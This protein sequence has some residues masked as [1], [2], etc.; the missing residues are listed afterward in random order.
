[1]TGEKSGRTKGTLRGRL[2]KTTL[3]AAVSVGTTVWLS[4]GL[5]AVTD[6][7]RARRIGVLPP[8][9]LLAVLVVAAIAVA[10]A[11]RLPSRTSLP[12][13]LSLLI[14][15][16]WIPLH[17]PDLFLAWTG[18]AVLFVWGAIALG[19]IAMFVSTRSVRPFAVVGDPR[20]APRV[21]AVLAFVTFLAVW[22]GQALPPNG[23]EPHYLVIAQSLLLDR[24]VKVS[25]NYER[26][27]YL[28][29][30]GGFLRPHVTRPGIDG[31]LYSLHA[32]GLPA[33]VA[34]AFA[35]GGYW[36]VVVW[37]AAFAAIGTALVWKA[38]YLLTRDPGAA[39][40][41]WA[42]VA[43]TVPVVLHGTLVYPDP[44]AGVVL[45]GGA[46]ALVV[47]SEHRRDEPT[48]RED[49][50]HAPPWPAWASL[51]LGVA[52]GA[53]PWLHTRLALPA[54]ILAALLV[55][56]IG[57]DRSFSV[58][59]WRH[60]V[61]FGA[62]IALL[63]AGWLAFFRI[64]YGSFNPA[65]PFGD[66]IPLEAG[67][68]ASGLLALMTDQEFG[69]IPNAPVHL[70]W[71][72]G[73][74]SV[75]RRNTRLGVELLLLVAPYAIAASAYP[76][77]WAGSSSPARFLVPIVF[78]LGV[79]VA[80][81]WAQQGGRGRAMSLTL[82][83]ASVMIATAFAF[84]GD[85][86]LAYNASTGRARW[87]D[88]A[89]PLVDLPRGFPS[90]FRAGTTVDPGYPMIAAELARPALF[91]GA[92]LVTGWVVFVALDKWLRATMPMRALT[93]PACLALACALGTTAS[94][95]AA[96]GGHVTA[97]RAQL[98]LL[99]GLNPHLRPLAGLLVPMRSLR[100][101]DVPA[102]L[103]ITTSPF[104][105]PPPGTLLYLQEV[106]P[107]DYRLRV[108]RKPL[109]RGELALGIG[110]A[111]QPAARWSV[112]AEQADG[113][114]LPVRAASVSVTGDAEA[115]RSI[116][117]VA[118]VPGPQMNT[119]PP[120]AARARDAA[121]YG[122]VVV[123]TLDDRVWLEP[124]GFWVMGE[125]QPEVVIAMD[126]RVGS[127]DVDMRNGPELNRV[128]VWAGAWSSERALGPDE[129]WHV[130]V[131]V[132]GPA[133][134]IIVGFKVQ[135]GFIPARIDP[136][137]RDHRSLGCWVE[138]H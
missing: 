2:S 129:L 27:D 97:T 24:D 9:W 77:W 57:R 137:S 102:R 132:S 23:D 112:S 99:R 40:F 130:R 7:D 123:Y 70:L 10:A 33:F 108:T 44:M 80:S 11:T 92:A 86:R 20:M 135:R 85:G 126:Q 35:L 93:A 87:L 89:G 3:A 49:E 15:L 64:T 96:G 116:E 75:F 39:W 60:L 122:S 56:H 43:L 54:G 114:Y 76:M 138:V 81:A 18:H 50:G 111:S 118:L 47:T 25:N 94:W 113:F 71:L 78:P 16:P 106:P 65:S 68:I 12:L 41:G 79:A 133:Q 119:P 62:P 4:L 61:L 124:Q 109:A 17:V 115:V 14:A 45:A 46:L 5:L 100:A 136:N 91:W 66:R 84:G 55:L 13:F 103:A 42:V 38:G 98:E 107:G 22:T 131:P 121:R 59:R 128:R 48:A 53:L 28:S 29:Y 110:R 52:I 8:L 51:G 30:Y 19:L 83:G 104:D 73:L 1:M 127:F 101:A 21:A 32:P 6:A 120:S 36:A 72:V 58:N 69:L 82:L 34:P 63:V 26:G 88:W 117:K 90:F 125:R 31:E 37:I 67:R 134:A 105:V 74:W 95:R